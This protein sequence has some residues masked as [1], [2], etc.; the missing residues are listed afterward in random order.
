MT[1]LC[2]FVALLFLCI[3]GTEGE[4]VLRKLDR[5]ALQWVFVPKSTTTPT[6]MPTRFPQQYPFPTTRTPSTPNYSFNEFLK[7]LAQNQNTFGGGNFNPPPAPAPYYYP[8]ALYPPPAPAPSVNW[9]SYYYT[10]AD[11]GINVQGRSA[12]LTSTLTGDGTKLDLFVRST[13]NGLYVKQW[14]VSS[15]WTQIP[16]I[17]AFSNPAAAATTLTK[18]VFVR[19]SANGLSFASSTSGTTYGSVTSYGTN[20]VGSPA[21]VTYMGIVNV[22]IRDTSNQLVQFQG[23][24]SSTTGTTVPT[25]SIGPFSSDPAAASFIGTNSNTYLVIV[26]CGVNNQPYAYTI[27]N[28]VGGWSQVSTQECADSPV[29]VSLANSAS[30]YIRNLADGRFY[31]YSYNG[32]YW[33]QGTVTVPDYP[34]GYSAALYNSALKGFYTNERARLVSSNLQ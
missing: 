13:G 4:N 30:F 24:P 2:K 19:N 23:I 20:F 33:S 15:S 26:I 7:Q 27:S 32:I 16:G 5:R 21:A 31:T 9:P 6:T 29:G 1:S 3:S 11:E 28:S 25:S 14:G 12:A 18:Y 34:F 8:G 17:T 22:F 10:V